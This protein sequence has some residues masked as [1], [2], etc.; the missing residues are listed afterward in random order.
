MTWPSRNLRATCKNIRG[1]DEFANHGFNKI[2]NAVWGIMRFSVTSWLPLALQCLFSNVF[3]A[4]RLQSRPW[5]MWA[6]WWP[7]IRRRVTP[8]WRMRTTSILWNPDI[9]NTSAEPDSTKADVH[10]ILFLFT[11]GVLFCC[12]GPPLCVPHVAEVCSEV[13][14][15]PSL[16]SSVSQEIVLIWRRQLGFTTSSKSSY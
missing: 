7:W 5:I 13:G 3:I 8:K 4:Y 2:R 10:K 11:L 1:A 14:S 6:V 16:P 9:L 12:R 15:S